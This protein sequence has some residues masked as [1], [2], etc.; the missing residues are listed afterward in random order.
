MGDK[1]KLEDLLPDFDEMDGEIVEVDP[2][3]QSG[4]GGDDFTSTGEAIGRGLDAA[5]H[6][7]FDP[8]NQGGAYEDESLVK[9]KGPRDST[10]GFQVDVEGRDAAM[11]RNDETYEALGNGTG[12]MDKVDAEG[13]PYKEFVMPPEMVAGN[14]PLGEAAGRIAASTVTK[15]GKGL[16][17]AGEWAIDTA[18]QSKKALDAAPDGIKETLGVIGMAPEAVSAF[19]ELI[20]GWFGSGISDEYTNWVDGNFPTA[21]TFNAAENLTSDIG[22]MAVGGGMGKKA[23]EGTVGKAVDLFFRRAKD[24]NPGSAAAATQAFTK[25]LVSSVPGEAAGVTMMGPDESVTGNPF[26][27]NFIL[28]AGFAAAGT[29]IGGAGRL[30]DQYPLA[31]FNNRT[32]WDDSLANFMTGIDPTIAGQKVSKEEAV[33][34]AKIFGEIVNSNKSFET[35]LK[36]VQDA[37]IPLD[38]TTA[39]VM[40]DAA[41]QYITRVAGNLPPEQLDAMAQKLIGNMRGLKKGRLMGG[42]EAIASSDANIN[43]ASENL[44]TEKANQVMDAPYVD[45]TISG[46]VEPEVNQLQDIHQ[47]IKNADNSVLINEGKLAA[48]QNDNALLKAIE[49]AKQQDVL[50]F[51]TKDKDAF[52]AMSSEGLVKSWK[53]DKANVDNLY[54]NIPNDPY[55]VEALADGIIAA[56]QADTALEALN[57]IP[58]ERTIKR[59]IPEGASPE[60][61]AA[62][63]QEL[64]TKLQTEFPDIN[65]LW[66]KGRSRI[67]IAT[68]AAITSGKDA[69]QVKSVRQLI[70]EI[71]GKSTN[72]QVKAANDVYAAFKQK[73]NKTQQ[74]TQFD[75]TMDQFK[76]RDDSLVPNQV[77]SQV[78]EQA[79][80]DPANIQIEPLF[81]AIRDPKAAATVKEYAVGRILSNLSRGMSADKLVAN[82]KPFQNLIRNVNPALEADFTATV[83]ALRNAEQGSDAAKTALANAQKLGT[84]IMAEASNKELSTFINGLGNTLDPLKNGA[85]LTGN[86]PATMSSIFN[87]KEGATRITKLIAEAKAAGHPMAEE[88]IKSQALRWLKDKVFSSNSTGATVLDS[89]V[90]FSKAPKIGTLKSIV[91]GSDDN[92]FDV[93]KA[94]F[95]NDPDTYNSVREI[96]EFIH[97]KVNVDT[98]KAFTKGSDTVPN[99]SALDA[100]KNLIIAKWGPLSRQGTIANRIA[101]LIFGDQ[102]AKAEDLMNSMMDVLIVNPSFFKEIAEVSKA[103]DTGIVE[104]FVTGVVNAGK[105]YTYG[106]QNTEDKNAPIDEQ[107]SEAFKLNP[108]APVDYDWDQA[109]VDELSGST[110]KMNWKGRPTSANIEDRRPKGPAF[111]NKGQTSDFM[112][113]SFA[114]A[115]SKPTP[116][117]SKGFSKRI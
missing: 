86:I 89:E 63:R 91:E 40:N 60:D 109:I 57:A 3:V 101:T 47:T 69:S 38:T 95:A 93:L 82:I 54:K 78:W 53:Q 75:E 31:G 112:T 45:P 108:N 36:S 87:S 11:Q 6:A 41:R 96:L 99:R 4:E 73:W 111:P 79:L 56:G 17:S 16:A 27:D 92:T 29:A 34:R 59:Q 116:T 103:K 117:A 97:T 50:G 7:L 49:D 22:A 61:A 18:T 46:L 39:L 80:T 115:R 83:T 104:S 88:A 9:F 113:E 26:L 24:V 30:L 42:S 58:G 43:K 23:A 55:D 102:S 20:D 13:D 71:V 114:S 81:D 15:V 1:K 72:P 25:A 52:N 8:T 100:T 5:K 68:D 77:A 12:I 35:G 14:N 70:D 48:E 67:S 62:L 90:S 37:S 10:G 84:Q 28:G 74:L 44:M 64:I 110:A 107:T 33:R 65:A 19:G 85:E 98:A 32:R 2:M 21:P 105:Y 106:T 51:N 66:N 94:A 76:N